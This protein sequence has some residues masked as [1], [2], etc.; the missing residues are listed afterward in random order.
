MKTFKQLREFK[1]KHPPGEHI[2]AKKVNGISTMIHKDKGKFVA[3]IDGDK[4][5]SY[6][7]QKEAERMINVFVKNYKG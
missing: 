3:Y 2:S 4:L 7:T 5:D 6:R 1:G